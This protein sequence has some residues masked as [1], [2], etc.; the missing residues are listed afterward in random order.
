MISANVKKFQLKTNLFV[1]NMFDWS[2]DSKLFV[3]LFGTNRLERVTQHR[4]LLEKHFLLLAAAPSDEHVPVNL[5]GLFYC[6]Y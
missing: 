1:M 5:I 6:I 4:V 2:T 3:L